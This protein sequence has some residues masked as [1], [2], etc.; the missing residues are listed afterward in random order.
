MIAAWRSSSG[1]SSRRRIWL[2]NSSFEGRERERVWDVFMWLSIW[3]DILFL[4]RQ[5]FYQLIVYWSKE[6]HKSM[7]LGE[8]G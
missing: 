5:K 4:M 3:G 7:R 8:I 6:W 1:L 2:S